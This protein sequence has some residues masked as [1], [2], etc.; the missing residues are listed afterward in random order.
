MDAEN[1]LS[2]HSGYFDQLQIEHLNE[3]PF[4]LWALAKFPI[5]EVK[6]DIE[7]IQLGDRDYDAFLN[8]IEWALN[9]NVDFPNKSLAYKIIEDEGKKYHALTFSRPADLGDFTIGLEAST[10][11]DNW[12]KIDSIVSE[13]FNEVNN[14]Y[15]VTIR[16]IQVLDTDGGRF[17]RLVVSDE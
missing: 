17:I 3:N 10:D 8:L 6:A 14:T 5:E 12:D 16:D 4:K 7:A 13:T 15:T 1:K 11:L 9:K 2:W